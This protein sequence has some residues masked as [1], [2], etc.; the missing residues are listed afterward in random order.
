[1]FPVVSGPMITA[2][3]LEPVV[4]AA[5]RRSL[6]GLPQPVEGLLNSLRRGFDVPIWD[7]SCGGWRYLIQHQIPHFSRDDLRAFSGI[8][9]AR[10]ETGTGRRLAEFPPR[11]QQRGPLQTRGIRRSGLLD[12]SR[13]SRSS[14]PI[15]HAPGLRT[16]CCR[17]AKCLDKQELRA[18]MLISYSPRSRRRPFQTTLAFSTQ[19]CELA[20]QPTSRFSGENS[21]EPHVYS[22]C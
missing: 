19:S 17:H 3:A 5:V 15:W 9:A 12:H 8:G 4:L 1:M 10:R 16:V 6:L 13:G 21:R 2:Q 18:S 14:V 7:E 20:N 22:S 11:L